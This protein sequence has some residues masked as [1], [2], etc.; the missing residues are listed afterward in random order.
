MR[1][2][3][4]PATDDRF[5]ADADADRRVSVALGVTV[6]V[7]VIWNL[8]RTSI[9]AEWL[10]GA[11]V[12]F[13]LLLLGLGFVGGLHWFD[14]GLARAR[15]PVGLMYG[16]GV[17]IV[18][19]FCLLVARWLPFVADQLADPRIEVT[20]SQ[21]LYRVL[22]EIPVGTV[23]LEEVAF[24]GTLFG[25]LDRGVSPI[26]PLVISAVL[27]GLWHIDS[28]IRAGHSSVF[29]AVGATLGTFVATTI[30]GVIFG[31]L[32]I[33]SGSLLAP[34]GAHLATNSVTFAVAWL[35]AH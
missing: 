31:W 1:H 8:T 13:T 25:L 28:V 10:L 12:G 4:N 3:V 35:F 32:R 23:L 26:R 19:G 5:G 20:T 15:V 6:A 29:V 7:L 16:L 11:S 2:R 34:I 18:V 27:F 9:P 14:L 30:A 22:V 21:M 17:M 24:R 33:R